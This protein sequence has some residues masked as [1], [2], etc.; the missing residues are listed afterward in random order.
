M[1]LVAAAGLLLMRISLLGL[2]L[3]LWNRLLL[4]TTSCPRPDGRARMRASVRDG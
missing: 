3:L 2:I 1:Q 4:P